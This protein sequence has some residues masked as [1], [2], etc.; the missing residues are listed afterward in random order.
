MKL[1]RRK[2]LGQHMLRDE[3]I[4]RKL[5]KM[6]V[7]DQNETVYEAGTG[8]GSLT[9]AL[10]KI[11]KSVVSF[12]IDKT[13]YN[14]SRKLLSS[15]PNLSLMNANIFEC[16]SLTFDVF[17]SN[18]PY[19]RSKQAL[20]W[21]PLQ[22]F[23]RAIITVQKEFADKLQASPGD[24][25]YRAISVIAQYCFNIEQLFFIP[26][27]SFEP[28]PKVESIVIRL[29]PKQTGVNATPSIIKNV[30]L[31]F[32]SRHKKIVSVLAKYNSKLEIRPN[33]KVEQLMPD[34]LIKLAE[35]ISIH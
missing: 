11:A 32:S 24:K 12:E 20:E 35:C 19:S 7:I 18:L 3:R 34:Q 23:N 26:K 4:I 21:L 5:L 22:S 6:S 2:L 28:Q 25:N 29:V 27:Y 30:N 15:F 10:C 33:E 1:P 14:R 8:D 13:L 31:L 17:I 16:F 9:R